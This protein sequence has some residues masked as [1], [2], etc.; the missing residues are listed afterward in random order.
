MKLLSA[1]ADARWEAKPRVMDA[2]KE[3]DQALPPTKP[4][5]VE[6]GATT[7]SKAAQAGEQRSPENSNSTKKQEDPWERAR[8]PSESWRPDAWKPT[9]AKKT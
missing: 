9:V 1:Q 8:G 5:A 6:D 2:P 4:P 3:H 7:Q